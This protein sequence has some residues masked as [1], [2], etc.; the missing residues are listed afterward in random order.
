[1]KAVSNFTLMIWGFGEKYIYLFR[2]FVKQL[3]IL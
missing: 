3:W 2:I 1:L